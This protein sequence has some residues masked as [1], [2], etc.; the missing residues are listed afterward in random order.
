[1]VLFVA[2]DINVDVAG[3]SVNMSLFGNTK[4]DDAAISE[5]NFGITDS[6]IPTPA[7]LVPSRFFVNPCFDR[8]TVLL[9]G[10]LAERFPYRSQNVSLR[11]SYRNAIS[12]LRSGLATAD[13]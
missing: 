11:H 3:C 2:A 4:R 13:D 9:F 5:N 6:A 1:M 7:A 10:A 12:R 8:D